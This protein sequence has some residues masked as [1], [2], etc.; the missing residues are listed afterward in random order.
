MLEIVIF[1]E[2]NYVSKT[3]SEKVSKFSSP[4]VAP[5]LMFNETKVLGYEIKGT[6]CIFYSYRPRSHSII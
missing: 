4:Q 6:E 5:T 1:Q 3:V 2:L